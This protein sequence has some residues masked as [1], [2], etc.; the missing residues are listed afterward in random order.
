MGVRPTIGDFRVRVR[1]K[2]NNSTS[3][4]AGGRID[5]ID[6]YDIESGVFE[7]W[8]HVELG[9]IR[10]TDELD[11]TNQERAYKITTRATFAYVP[12][13]MPKKNMLVEIVG[14]TTNDAVIQGVMWDDWFQY[15][16]IEA[17][18]KL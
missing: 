16:I 14:R 11:R 8:A 2:Y 10:R 5:D 7:C 4:G 9:R 1:I 13:R 12:D 15:W 17:I 3:D 6:P 18:E